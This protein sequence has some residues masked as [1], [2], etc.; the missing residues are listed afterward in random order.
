MNEVPK[1]SIGDF[2]TNYGKAMPL[3]SNVR[4]VSQTVSSGNGPYNEACPPRAL[5][6]VFSIHNWNSQ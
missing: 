1:V 2:E 4:T 5:L 6:M 3:Y